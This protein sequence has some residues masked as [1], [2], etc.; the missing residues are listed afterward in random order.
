MPPKPKCSKE[1]I[2]CAAYEI[3][4]ES[5]INAVV[6]REVGKKLG[7]TA[8]PIF[9]FFSGMD[10]LKEEVYQMAKQQ[11][12]D[13]LKPSLEY[14]PA[15]KEFGM[16]WIRFARENPRVYELLFL[17]KG[18]E[19]EAYG[20]LNPDFLEVLAPMKTELVKTFGISESDAESLIRDMCIFAQGIAT[21]FVNGLGEFSE[22]DISRTLSRMC[23]SY[24]AGCRIMDNSVNPD[25]IR[26]MF[27]CLETLPQHK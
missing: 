26:K 4:K 16:R 11:C 8:G 23:I 15:F 18:T 1:D 2:I 24:V 14:T 21:F 25:E 7:T 13:Y 27:T 5:G 17:M 9:T 19:R 6:A 22:E 10:E 3:V 20:F 12:L